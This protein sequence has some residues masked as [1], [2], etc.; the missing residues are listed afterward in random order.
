LRKVAIAVEIPAKNRNQA[1]GIKKNGSTRV[2]SSATLEPIAA[3]ATKHPSPASIRAIA[4]SFMSLTLCDY[5]VVPQPQL[6][7]A[8]SITLM[9]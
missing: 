4:I 3:K 7:S 8:P 2:P 5:Q 9:E 6:L 1:M